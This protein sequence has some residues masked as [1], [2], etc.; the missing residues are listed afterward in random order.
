MLLDT[1][2]QKVLYDEGKTTGVLL[3]SGEEYAASAIVLATGGASV[4]Q[5]GSTGDGYPWAKAAGHTITELF[6]TEVPITSNEGFIKEKQLQGLSLRDVGL[7]VLKPNGKPVITHKMD[8]I[9]THLGAFPA[10]PP[11]AVANLS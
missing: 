11:Y 2:V 8:M 9:F 4:P 1:P 3:K 7:S 5:T 10:L 6:P